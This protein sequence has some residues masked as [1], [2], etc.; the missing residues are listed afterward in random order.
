MK[1]TFVP[2]LSDAVLELNKSGDI[3]TINGDELDFSDLPEG[4]EYPVGSIN[5][6]HVLGGV[7]RNNGH[8]ELSIILPFSNIFWS[9]A[10][11]S[12]VCFV[13]SDGPID[14]PSGRNTS[15]DYSY[16]AE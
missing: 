11:K 2:Q 13:N 8:V 4:G 9:G 7:S 12:H 15:K 5:N 10:S 14:M 16:A 6:P 1:I 3:L